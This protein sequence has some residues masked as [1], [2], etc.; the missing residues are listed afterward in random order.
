M[1][2]SPPRPIIPAALPPFTRGGRKRTAAGLLTCASGRTL[3]RNTGPPSRVS[4]MADRR[5]GSDPLRSQR[6]YR[7]RFTRDSLFSRGGAPGTASALRGERTQYNR[8]FCFLQSFVFFLQKYAEST[9]YPAR[10]KPPREG[11]RL[12]TDAKRQKERGD[13]PQKTVKNHG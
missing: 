8:C 5:H 6:R 2:R 3:P 12:F 4:P 9:K 7:S 11:R 1:H 13:I 10:R